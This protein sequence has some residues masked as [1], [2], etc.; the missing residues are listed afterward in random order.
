MARLQ[1]PPKLMQEFEA[2]VIDRAELHAQMARHA[3]ALIAEMEIEYAHPLETMWELLRNRH[4]AARLS[5]RHGE[6]RVREVLS[7]LSEMEDFS[8]ASLL[9]NAG[10][11]HV[12]LHCFVR[13][14]RAPI[15]R[16]KKMTST[17]VSVTIWIE[18]NE[19]DGEE[20]VKEK[21]HLLRN[22]KWV[23]EVVRREKWE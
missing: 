20:V 17:A 12:P 5:A 7:A 13:C 18:Y 3:R 19:H 10:H 4:Q 14:K 15:F 21:I 9:W 8:P 2:G 6:R 22:R 11:V 1:T 16:V 23:L